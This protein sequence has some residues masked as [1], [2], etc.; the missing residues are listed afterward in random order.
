[1]SELDF[2]RF[3]ESSRMVAIVAPLNCSTEKVAIEINLE[4]K[5]NQ[6]ERDA[7]IIVTDMVTPDLDADI[8]I[9]FETDR[10]NFSDLHHTKVMAM[11]HPPRKICFVVGFGTDRVKFQQLS[12]YK[13]PLLYA[14]FMEIPL[15]VSL[16]MYHVDK[17]QDNMELKGYSRCM[18]ERCPIEEQNYVQSDSIN[19]YTVGIYHISND[20]SLKLIRRIMSGGGSATKEIFAYYSEYNHGDF[21]LVKAEFEMKMEIFKHLKETCNTYVVERNTRLYVVN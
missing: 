9:I 7:N 1:M 18:E 17:M 12:I 16:K 21:D 10:T 15:N 4:F 19:N 20:L 8:L 3:T 11:D 2:N 5:K 14:S 6:I 13:I